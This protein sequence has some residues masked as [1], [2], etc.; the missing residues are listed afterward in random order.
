MH[1]ENQKLCG[2]FSNHYHIFLVFFVGIIDKFYRT[3]ENFQSSV[4]ESKFLQIIHA[5]TLDEHVHAFHCRLNLSTEDCRCLFSVFYCTS[6][7]IA[8]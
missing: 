7:S 6:S 8:G 5:T 3:F 2:F 1:R 4:D